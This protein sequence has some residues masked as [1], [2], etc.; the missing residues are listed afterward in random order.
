MVKEKP[1]ER[2]RKEL[3]KVLQSQDIDYDKLLGLSSKLAAFDNQHVRFSVDAGL[4]N[5]LGRELVA[6]Q[7]TAVS[8]LV[9]NAYDADATWVELS[10][11]D[12]EKPGGTLKLEDDGSGMNRRELINGFMRLSSTDKVDN[13]ISPLFKRRRAGQKGIGRFA[14]QRLGNK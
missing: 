11:E 9:K 13:P 5:R 8:E 10:F 2:L 4:I 6:R 12:G 7:E 1:S 14:A 3:L